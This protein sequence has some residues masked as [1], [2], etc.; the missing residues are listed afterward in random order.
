MQ[1]RGLRSQL[2]QLSFNRSEEKS[3]NNG[4]CPREWRER[5]GTRDPSFVQSLCSLLLLLTDPV[6]PRVYGVSQFMK[7]KAAE[8]YRTRFYC[9][10]GFKFPKFLYVIFLFRP[11]ERNLESFCVC[12]QHGNVVDP[13]AVGGIGGLGKRGKPGNTARGRRAEKMWDMCTQA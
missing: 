3:P 7:F 4:P 10:Q 6:Y 1:N 12:A 13:A 11:V 2:S 5:F 8:R 9:Y